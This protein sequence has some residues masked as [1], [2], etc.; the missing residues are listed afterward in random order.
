MKL[1]SIVTTT[2]AFG[3]VMLPL[4]TNIPPTRAADSVG[5]RGTIVSVDGSVLTVKTREGATTAVAL[6]D[7]WKLTGLVKALPDDIKAGEFV[8]IASTPTTAAGDHSLEVMIFPPDLNDAGEGNYAW[9]LGA[10]GA[11]TSATVSYAVKSPDGRT[12]TISYHGLERR[13]AIAEGTPVVTFAG[14]SRTEL[15]AGA[16]VLIPAEPS[17]DGILT[18]R[19]VIVDANGVVPP[20]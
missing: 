12:L 9:L 7:G 2:G 11:M 6:K 4:L 19:L 18:A 14:A 17:A 1:M 5:V 20:M 13:I 16:S 10:K 3:A 15:T 8:G